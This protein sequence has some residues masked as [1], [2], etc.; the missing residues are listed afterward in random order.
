MRGER[1]GEPA[2]FAPAHRIGLAGDREG[3]GAGFADPSGREMEVGD[4]IDLIGAGGRLVYPL[5]EPSDGARR[6]G[7]QL[8]ETPE[9]G[10]GTYAG[11]RPHTPSIPPSNPVPELPR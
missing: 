10:G 2:D 3:R 8:D 4:R 5:A 1:R 11:A 7:E 9:V 6:C